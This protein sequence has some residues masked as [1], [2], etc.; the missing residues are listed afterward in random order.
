MHVGTRPQDS[1][2]DTLAILQQ[3]ALGA[4]PAP[5]RRI[6]A[7]DRVPFFAGTDALS[8]QARSQSS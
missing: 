2:R 4:R 1:Q 7:D 8:I 5:V 6:E 3:V